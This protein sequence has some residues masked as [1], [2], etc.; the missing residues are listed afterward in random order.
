MG[1]IILKEKLSPEEIEILDTL[2]FKPKIC[3]GDFYVEYL[4]GK[5]E[6]TLKEL[7]EFFPLAY[8]APQDQTTSMNNGSEEE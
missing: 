4:P 8:L 2:G 6:K 5:S 7:R 1:T 3:K